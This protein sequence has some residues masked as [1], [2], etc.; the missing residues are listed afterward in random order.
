MADRAWLGRNHVYYGSGDRYSPNFYGNALNRSVSIMKIDKSLSIKLT[1]V[2]VAMTILIVWLH[3]APIFNLPQWVQQIAIIAV[4]CFWTISSFL[5]FASFDFSSPWI[6]YKSK[7]LARTRTILVPFI[8][9][10]IFGLLFSLT[11]LQIHPVDSTSTL[12]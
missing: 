11:L 6:S 3:I 1:E 4:P 2:N 8:V 10:N 5:Y 7:L 9:F 12:S